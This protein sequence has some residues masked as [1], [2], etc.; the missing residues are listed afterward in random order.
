MPRWSKPRCLRYRFRMS[1]LRIYVDLAM[2][3]DALSVLRDGAAG[4]ELI[5]PAKPIR[6]VLAKAE[7]DPAF[8]T[9]DVAFGQ[10]DLQSIA[11]AEK[12]RWIHVSSSGITRYDTAE[13]RAIMASRGV[14]VSNSA[15]VY[16]EGCAL[17]LLS[18]L[19][20]QA[21]NIPRGLASH[22]ANGSAE[23]IHLRETCR[24]LQGETAVILGY[25]AIGKRLAELLAPLNMRVTAYRRTP[26]GD[27]GIPVI[28]DDAL[29]ST[30]A[31][32]DHVI[33]ILPE[34]ASTRRFFD[35]ARFGGLKRGAIFYNIGR[36]A[37]VDQAALA[38]AL[39]SG[40]VGAAWLDVTEPEPLPADHPLRKEKNCFITPHIAGGHHDETKS[41]VRHFLANLARFTQDEP[42]LDRVM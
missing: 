39:A 42:L 15:T 25:G 7:L 37:T 33:N 31:E 10:P 6:S 11:Q 9:V 19:L 34:S 21:R 24:V 5:F 20:A 8:A 18:F 3:S 26:R 4:H 16:Q 36:G 17:H 12:L 23:W 32:A 40:Q 30:L 35:S 29:T 2:P 41:L 13:F 28:T 22:A 14:S 27:E 1:R 38:E